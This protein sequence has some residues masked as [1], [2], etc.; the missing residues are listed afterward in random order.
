MRPSMTIHDKIA[1]VVKPFIGRTLRAKEI[2]ALV[3]QEYPDANSKSV[4]VSDHS[5]LSPTGRRYRFCAL[6][7]SQIFA[8][9]DGRYE[10]ALSSAVVCRALYP[11]QAPHPKPDS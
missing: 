9:R 5:G 2:Q 7:P 3:R 11:T 8:R 10:V 6:T 1:A 4:V